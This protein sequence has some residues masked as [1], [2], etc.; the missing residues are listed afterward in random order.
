MEHPVGLFVKVFGAMVG[1]LLNTLIEFSEHLSVNI[2]LRVVWCSDFCI[3]SNFRIRHRSI[4]ISYSLKTCYF[5]NLS[6]RQCNWVFSNTLYALIIL[7]NL[8]N[9]AVKHHLKPMLFRVELRKV[10]A[11]K[12][13]V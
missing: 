2:L 8:R 4:S 1:Q 10:L 3:F 9:N 12:T 13:I 5:H 11:I 6:H 7:E